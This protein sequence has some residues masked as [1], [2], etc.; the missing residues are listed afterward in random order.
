MACLDIL[1]RTNDLP[2]WEQGARLSQMA[3][4]GGGPVATALV[5]A[6]RLGANTAMITNYGND[7][8]G[9]IKLQT[10][11]ENGV[12]TSHMPRRPAPESHVILVTVHEQTGERVFS[13]IMNDGYSP[14][15]P[16]ELDHNFITSAKLL[17]LDGCN[18]DSAIQAA[19]WMRSLGKPVMLDGSS[20]S[21]PLP[22]QMRRIVELTDILI[23]GAGFGTALT[24]KKD[25]RQAAEAIMALGPQIIVQTEGADGSYTLTHD[26]F[27]HTPAF[28]VQVVDTTGA[29]D[30][31]H[32]AY[33]VGMLHG[34]SPRAN[35]IFSSAVAAVKC[36]QL[37]GRKGIPNYDQTMD[38]LKSRGIDPAS[39]DQTQ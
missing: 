29:G 9:E 8:L 5:A 24:G 1:I 25:L 13:G 4:E 6:Q 31:F 20:T 19:Q 27:F 15:L 36:T 21:G 14:I 18:P 33:L 12:D 32:G 30:V 37:S 26:T 17:H 35:A 22:P 2:T 23:C 10:I 39:L 16:D 3:I 11:A 7:R 34:W 28:P 38:F